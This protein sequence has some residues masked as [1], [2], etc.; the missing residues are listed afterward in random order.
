MKTIVAITGAGWDPVTEVRTRQ[1]G[2]D[3]PERAPEMFW[4]VGGGHTVI[5]RLIC[6]FRGLGAETIFVGMG[7]PGC[8]PILVEDKDKRVYGAVVP[9]YGRSPWTEEQVEYV[10]DHGAIPV[11]MPNPSGQGETCWSTLLRMRPIILD[12]QWDRVVVCAGDYIFRT[13]FLRRLYREA[14]W[15]SQFWFWTKHSMEFLD[16]P[17]F[18]MFTDFL[19]GGQRQSRV[20]LKRKESGLPQ[21]VWGKREHVFTWM[22]KDWMEVGPHVWGAALKLAKEDP[23]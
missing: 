5:S 13:D 22:K 1:R 23:A 9:N 2:F 6:Q 16:R 14:T 4:D 21:T 7:K 18:I 8:S 19:V 17:G 11:L 20:W 12:E 15:P 10:T 3:I